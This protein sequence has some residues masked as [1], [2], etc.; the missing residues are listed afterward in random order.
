MDE[1]SRQL[2]NLTLKYDNL[3]SLVKDKNQT[4]FVHLAPIE[5]ER[6]E[7]LQEEREA[8]ASRAEEV[9]VLGRRAAEDMDV[10][11][12]RVPVEREAAGG[13]NSYGGYGPGDAGGCS[14]YGDN[15]GYGQG[16]A[17][18]YF[19]GGGN[20]NPRKTGPDPL[21]V[22][23]AARAES[24]VPI[25]AE[26]RQQARDLSLELDTAHRMSLA[27]PKSQVNHVGMIVEEEQALGQEDVS[28]SYTA[29]SAQVDT[30][31][32]G[33]NNSGAS[34][35]G[36]EM[37]EQNDCPSLS[38][39]DLASEASESMVS[40]SSDSVDLDQ[41]ETTSEASSAR[42]Q[43][44]APEGW[45][46]TGQESQRYG[47]LLGS[48]SQR[49]EQ[50]DCRFTELKPVGSGAAL[51]VGGQA[52]QQA[53]QAHGAV[54]VVISWP[55]QEQSSQAAALDDVSSGS[56]LLQPQESSSTVP[57]LMGSSFGGLLSGIDDSSL[58]A[59]GQ[60]PMDNSKFVMMAPSLEDDWLVAERILAGDILIFDPGGGDAYSTSNRFALDPPGARGRYLRGAPG[61]RATGEVLASSAGASCAGV[62]PDTVVFDPG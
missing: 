42:V 57:C 60:V 56:F 4:H 59:A 50:A 7:E 58:G 54:E 35:A 2:R 26:L 38:N 31:D 20:L 23:G 53:Q 19:P 15:G 9:Y 18:D 12:L 22:D 8:F 34:Q 29:F 62:Q 32:L 30:V 17:G 11:E 40:C 49:K 1:L 47:R 48:G 46:R 39:G 52:R 14:G 16:G 36:G 3:L 5:E 28:Y 45:A 27:K 51:A 10:D 25:A 43:L 61:G 13:N 41:E 21:T 37:V 24:A 55:P 44:Q 33:T 6:E